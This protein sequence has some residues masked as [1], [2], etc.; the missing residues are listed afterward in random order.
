MLVIAEILI[1]SGVLGLLR[2]AWRAVRGVP[3]C[4]DD[5]IFL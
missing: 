5:F 3:R 2:L 4:N 1:L